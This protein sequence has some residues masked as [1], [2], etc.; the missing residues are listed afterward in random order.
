MTTTPTLEPAI[1]TA[2]GEDTITTRTELAPI[3][4]THRDLL[5]GPYWV[6]L[7][8]LMPDGQPQ[9][10]PVWCNRAG[11]YV[12]TNTMRGFRKEQNMRANPRVTLLVY[13]P[14][15]P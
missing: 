1:A 2:P 4:E 11:A 14:R 9:C 13:D 10:T 5:D 15:D 6:A 7:T 12:L 3:P 8:T